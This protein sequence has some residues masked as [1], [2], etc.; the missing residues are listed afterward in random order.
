MRGI[1]RALEF[2]IAKLALD[3]VR[4]NSISAE[5]LYANT[6]PPRQT[7]LNIHNSRKNTMLL[8]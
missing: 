4:E 2:Q 6:K 8:S 7:E 1:I 3:V 5:F